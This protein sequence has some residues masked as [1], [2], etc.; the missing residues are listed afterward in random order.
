VVRALL[1]SL[2]KGVIFFL[3]NSKKK[4]HLSLVI[5]ISVNSK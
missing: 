2:I 3:Q 4:R 1:E 5:K